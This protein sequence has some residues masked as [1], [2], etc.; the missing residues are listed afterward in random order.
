MLDRLDPPD[1]AKLTAAYHAM[2]FVEDDMRIGLGTGSTAE[3]LV[4]LLGARSYLEG[5]RVVAVSTSERTEALARSVGLRTAT[6]EEAGWLDLTIDGADEVDPVLSLIKG[7][8]GSLLRE[9]IVAAA[10]E[11]MVVI[12]DD[13]K[14]VDTLGAFPLPVEVVRFGWT[15]TR[16]LIEDVLSSTDLDGSTISPRMKDGA[17]F[18]TDEGHYILD[19]HL[20]Y[21]DDVD[22]LAPRLLAVPGVV[23]T[24]LFIDIAD[25]AVFGFASGEVHELGADGE[26][27]RLDPPQDERMQRILA[28]L[29]IRG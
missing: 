9:K 26:T 20:E 7:G 23:E 16:K 11:R 19:L 10:S 22:S 21:I 2:Q 17:R 13:G 6:L 8:G 5:L 1:R 18:V 25:T 28:Q 29:D 27:R 24:G 3:W 12:A 14:R 15:A 4:R